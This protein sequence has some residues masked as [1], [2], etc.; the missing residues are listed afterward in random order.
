MAA[1]AEPHSWGAVMQ[2]GDFIAGRW[3][4]AALATVG[5]DEASCTAGS[6]R[7]AAQ[8][9]CAVVPPGQTTLPLPVDPSL[10]QNP[11]L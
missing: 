10:D 11:S 4:G 9:V 6:G 7:P 3:R 8:A 5:V 2:P 1:P